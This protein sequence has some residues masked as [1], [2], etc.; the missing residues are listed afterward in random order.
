MKDWLNAYYGA[1]IKIM[2]WRSE[3]KIFSMQISIGLISSRNRIDK[4]LNSIFYEWL[5]KGFS[6]FMKPLYRKTAYKSIMTI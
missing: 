5:D 2:Q 6:W 1:Y 4:L 3:F